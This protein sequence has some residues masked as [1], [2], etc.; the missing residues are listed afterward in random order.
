[1]DQPIPLSLSSLLLAQDVG[2]LVPLGLAPLVGA[3]LALGE[4]EGAL[5][6]AGLWKRGRGERA[7]SIQRNPP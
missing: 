1:M 6:A 7:V 4:L 5:L 2:H 3:Q